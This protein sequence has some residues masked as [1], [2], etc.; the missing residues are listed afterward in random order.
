V[1][2]TE[3]LWAD[4][5]AFTA[6]LSVTATLPN[7][8][9]T[10]AVTHDGVVTCQ[11]SSDGAVIVTVVVPPAGGMLVHDDGWSDTAATSMLVSD[12]GA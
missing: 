6:T 10:L 3:P 2:T 9:V 8:D 12:N 11:A 7:P 4:E 1:N 5:V